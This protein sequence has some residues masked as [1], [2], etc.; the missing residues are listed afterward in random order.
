M[1][2]KF[3]I[4]SDSWSEPG[5]FAWDRGW[6]G[7][8]NI[9]PYSRVPWPLR[10]GCGTLGRCV[11]L[12][13]VE[14]QEQQGRCAELHCTSLTRQGKP[15]ESLMHRHTQDLHLVHFRIKEILKICY[16]NEVFQRPISIFKGEVSSRQIQ[17]FFIGYSQLFLKMIPEDSA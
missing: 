13:E 8:F 1:I 5:A 17:I 14:R 7:V 16:I 11:P 9:R 12:V 2:S 3:S 6:P 10:G 4:S 15:L